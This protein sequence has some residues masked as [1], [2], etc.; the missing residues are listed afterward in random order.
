MKVEKGISLT[1]SFHFFLTYRQREHFFWKMA[2]NIPPQFR[3]I[4]TITDNEDLDEKVPSLPK[5]TLVAAFDLIHPT[6]EE[7]LLKAAEEREKTQKAIQKVEEE[8]FG[9]YKCIFYGVSITTLLLFSF[10]NW[11]PLIK[12]PFF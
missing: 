10:K 8:R 9:L 3:N 7:E 2:S 4:N 5:K 11:F 6:I 12:N 1:Y